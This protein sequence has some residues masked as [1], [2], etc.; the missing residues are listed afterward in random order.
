MRKEVLDEVH[1]AEVVNDRSVPL[2]LLLGRIAAHLV[3][4]RRDRDDGALDQV[5]GKVPLGTPLKQEKQVVAP[6]LGRPVIL[7]AVAPDSG[8][9]VAP[10]SV[11][12]VSSADLAVTFGAALGELLEFRVANEFGAVLFKLIHHGAPL[13]VK[14]SELSNLC[15]VCE[16][17]V[18][19]QFHQILSAR[20]IIAFVEDGADWLNFDDEPS[21]VEF[22]GLVSLSLLSLVVEVSGAESDREGRCT[23]EQH[24]LLGAETC[25]SD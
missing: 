11:G 8:D 15:F 4:G 22:L 14:A 1:G 3:L 12:K 16:V 13:S 24:G 20:L 6:V 19:I 17:T 5:L 18:L 2:S 21:C 7:V 10:L 9:L 25:H 23:Y